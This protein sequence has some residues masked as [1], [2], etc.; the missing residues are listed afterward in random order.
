MS[1]R[2]RPLFPTP[3]KRRDYIQSLEL[4]QKTSE[5]LRT[6][7]SAQDHDRRHIV[8]LEKK[9]QALEA[10]LADR[11]DDFKRHVESMGHMTQP[12]EFPNG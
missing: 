3:Q 7:I 2:S 9:V 10:L 8:I 1:D 5:L 11:A 12:L 6:M 4:P